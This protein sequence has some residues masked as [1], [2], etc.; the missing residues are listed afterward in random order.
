M[1]DQAFPLIDAPSGTSHSSLGAISSVTFPREEELLSKTTVPSVTDTANDLWVNEEN[2]RLEIGWA[3]GAFSNLRASVWDL[4]AVASLKPPYQPTLILY[5]TL[6]FPVFPRDTLIWAPILWEI[7][8]FGGGEIS[9]NFLSR[10]FPRR[11][12]RITVYE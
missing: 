5:E 12:I 7:L 4:A 1:K 6:T 8:G 9:P 10:K 3:F 11:E 2:A